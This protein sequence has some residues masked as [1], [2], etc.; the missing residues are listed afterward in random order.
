MLGA[1]VLDL[2]GVRHN[3]L[4]YFSAKLQPKVILHTHRHSLYDFLRT[5][6]PLPHL[7]LHNNIPRTRQLVSTTKASGVSLTACG[8]VY[9]PAPI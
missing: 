5:L 8:K 1:L 2:I 9:G 4:K 7:S 3:F 6:L